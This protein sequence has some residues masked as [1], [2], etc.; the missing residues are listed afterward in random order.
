MKVFYF[1]TF[2]SFLP[3]FPREEEGESELV[4]KSKFPNIKVY[5][6]AHVKKNG[7]KAK[8]KAKNGKQKKGGK[9]GK[10]KRGKKRT[11]KGNKLKVRNKLK[12]RK[13]MRK[14]KRKGGNRKAKGQKQETSNCRNL[15]CLNDLLEVLKVDKD[16]VQNFIQQNRR[17]KSRLELAGFC[18]T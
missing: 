1:H 18:L 12:A 9:K 8:K 11:K 7:Q 6:D 4:R 16:T 14:A 5:R 2:Q 10:F 17:L 15:T 3:G 13:K